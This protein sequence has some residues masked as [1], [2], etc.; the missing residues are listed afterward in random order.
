M[1]LQK[2]WDALLTVVTGGQSPLA[3]KGGAAG[4]SGTP[5]PAAAADGL[6]S[7]N[8]RN[9]KANAELLQEVYRV[10]FLR[11]PADRGEF[12][13]LVDTLNQGASFE[14]L[15][16]GFTHS[17]EYRKLEM[18]NA[19][20][21]PGALQAFGEELAWLEA[22]LPEPFVFGASATQPLAL[23]VQPEVQP[24]PVPSAAFAAPAAPGASASG[25]PKADVK[26]LAEGYSRQFVGSSI[27][28]LKRVLGDEA[29]RVMTA[30]KEYPEKMALWYSQWVAR[31]AAK[32]VDFGVPLRNKPDEQLHY[33]WALSA[34]EDRIKWEV[35]N[36]VHR[37]L[38]EANK[39]KQ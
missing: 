14:G 3:R 28:T 10:V 23:P 30:K 9:A 31:L 12:G 39:P 25:A 5:S 24:E 17:S 13:N 4:P 11:E 21:S 16:N 15:Y 6:S 32:G 7:Q 27:F 19:G 26:A 2:E 22:E 20:A 37:V 36:R 33:R 1:Q 29:L 18:A 8:A 34:S 38:N 35:L